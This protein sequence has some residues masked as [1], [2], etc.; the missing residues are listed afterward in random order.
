MQIRRDP[1]ARLRRVED[2]EVLALEP[3]IGQQRQRERIDRAGELHRA[4]AGLEPPVD[5]HRRIRLRLQRDVDLAQLDAGHDEPR[6]AVGKLQ[7][8][9]EARPLRRAAQRD[10]AA[11]PA[12]EG[13]QLWQQRLQEREI[14]QIRLQ[15][16]AQRA[17][18]EGL[19]GRRRNIG[20]QQPLRRTQ[21][22]RAVQ[23]PG[24]LVR[25]QRAGLELQRRRVRHFESRLAQIQRDHR[26]GDIAAGE[27]HVAVAVE[28]AAEPRLCRQE[29]LERAQAEALDGPGHARAVAEHVLLEREAG[30]AIA[31]LQAARFERAPLPPEQQA[32]ALRERPARRAVRREVERGQ[33]AAPF[34]PL[35]IEAALHG[36]AGLAA[37]GVGQQLETMPDL[38]AAELETN[39]VD[40]QA[41]LRV[42]EARVQRRV[43]GGIEIGAPAQ[44]AQALLAVA[45][46]RAFAVA[47][48]VRPLEIAGEREIEAGL[49]GQARIQRAEIGAREAAAGLERRRQL[50]AQVQAAAAGTQQEL[51]Q[52]QRAQL[53][54]RALG[55]EPQRIAAQ[56]GIGEFGLERDRRLRLARGAQREAAVEAAGPAGR[57]EGRIEIDQLCVEIR[58]H[59][60]RPAHLAGRVDA[61][62]AGRER[63]PLQLHAARIG[64]ALGLQ[65]ERLAA[66]RGAREIERE[67]DLRILAGHRRLGVEPAVQIARHRGC[68]QRGIDM[69]EL[70]LEVGAQQR[71]PGHAAARAQHAVRAGG[72]RL[73]CRCAAGCARHMVELQMVDLHGVETAAALGRELRVTA[74]ERGLR[75]ERVAVV[76]EATAEGERT[77]DLA[78][79]RRPLRVRDKGPAQAFEAQLE[80]ARDGL[81]AEAAGGLDVPR[82]FERELLE[83]DRL[84]RHAR[85]RAQLQRAGQLKRGRERLHGDRVAMP[86]AREARLGDVKRRG[87]V[88]P[89]GGIQAEIVERE[90]LDD[91]IERQTHRQHGRRRR[92]VGRRSRRD[93]E[94]LDIDDFEVQL[95]LQ[96]RARCEPRMQMREA[97]HGAIAARIAQLAQIELAEQ[98]AADLADLHHALR[99]PLGLRERE[100]QA[101]FRAQQI[102]ER[103]GQRERQQQRQQ[104]PL[105]TAATLARQGR[106]R[107]SG[108]RRRAHRPTRTPMCS[109]TGEAPGSKGCARSSASEPNGAR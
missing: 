1:G 35:A 14:R 81:K 26:V 21:L 48:E 95:P 91:D 74:I 86:V 60:R 54:Q 23:A 63:E 15:M 94:A 82:S 64:R 98:A 65:R 61:A 5:A 109:R 79:Q 28:A 107:R 101:G 72:L 33:L 13:T 18:V 93:D 22:D 85:L 97:D 39:A 102:A 78:G 76:L 70:G 84:R 8:A 89:A 17:L 105:P 31:A 62:L 96:Q 73:A 77:A 53:G 44:R 32:G 67:A 59:R 69:L 49:A 88:R 50:A 12:A 11:E 3:Q 83:V 55:G 92:L 90:R 103:A 108:W 42:R 9:L 2:L 29:Q 6:V 58:R 75:R 34:E 36:D 20:G 56:A 40:M 37:L 7:L 47:H 87:I 106:R 80:I 45:D 104:P 66:Q 30:A 99:E 57:D 71:R 4:V 27:V 51:L 100:A 10:I 38:L 68:E 41:E 25:A 43:R 19:A 46:R 52:P 24:R 16:P